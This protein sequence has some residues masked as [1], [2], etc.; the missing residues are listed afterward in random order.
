MNTRTRRIS[1]S[2]WVSVMFCALQ[3][4][5]FHRSD[6]AQ[7]S[8]CDAA[9][10]NIALTES[11]FCHTKYHPKVLH[12]K[13]RYRFNPM[14]HE[15]F[16]CGRRDVASIRREV[17]CLIGRLGSHSSLSPSLVSSLILRRTGESDKMREKETGI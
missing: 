2:E 5:D 13:D 15:L 16:C 8:S 1:R 3:S 7:Q 11:R 9:T 12:V 10:E 14:F 17:A 4:G 6:C